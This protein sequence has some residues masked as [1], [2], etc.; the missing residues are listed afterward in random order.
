MNGPLPD[1]K[2]SSSGAHFDI[3]VFFNF[4]CTTE[5]LFNHHHARICSSRGTLNKKWKFCFCR[6]RK[7]E[8][9]LFYCKCNL[10]TQ[11]LHR[12]MMQINVSFVHF[13]PYRKTVLH[14]TKIVPWVI[15]FHKILARY[16]KGIIGLIL[17]VC[18]ESFP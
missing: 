1:N 4:T 8:G 16:Q 18:N 15:F 13:L 7:F 5:K 10:F 14:H 12:C 11:F 17:K 2:K 3:R 6:N 9:N